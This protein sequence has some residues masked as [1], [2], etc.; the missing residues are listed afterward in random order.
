MP[1]DRVYDLDDPQALRA[2]AH[3]LRGRLLASLRIDGPAT[4][5][6]LARRFEESSGSTSYHLRELERYGFVEDDRDRGSGRER[7]WRAAHDYTNWSPA[8][9]SGGDPGDREA[10]RQFLARTGRQYA[11]LF[12]RW[13]EELDNWPEAWQ[14]ASL[15]TDLFLR[16]TPAQ[17]QAL[18]E[19]LDAVVQR[20]EDAGPDG[21]DAERVAVILQ[22]F[23]QRGPYE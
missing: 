5:S 1:R 10:A 13:V 22:A 17:L 8:T 7:W 23:P 6:Q 4:A 15:S 20:Y 11:R 16:L 2:L 3:P 9:F 14:R 19:E 21:D 12:A 18:T